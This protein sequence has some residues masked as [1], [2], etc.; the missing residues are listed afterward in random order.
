MTA[1][2]HAQGREPRRPATRTTS[3]PLPPDWRTGGLRPEWADAEASRQRIRMKVG[4]QPSSST[5]RESFSQDDEVVVEVVHGARGSGLLN[6]DASPCTARN[7][8][9]WR[10][11]NSRSGTEMTGASHCAFC[12]KL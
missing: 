11:R 8:G 9:G 3:L 6:Q 7:P 10:T 2:T 4:V 5:V 1:E 12:T